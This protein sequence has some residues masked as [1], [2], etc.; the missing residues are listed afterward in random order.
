VNLGKATCVWSVRWWNDSQTCALC[1]WIVCERFTN[2]CPV[3]VN[4]HVPAKFTN[5]GHMLVKRFTNTGHI[6][7]FHRHEPCLT[8]SIDMSCKSLLQKRFT[9]TG[10]MLVK[11]FT[12]MCPVF[13]NRLWTIH[14]H[15]PCV[16]ESTCAC[17]IHKHRAHVAETI[18]KHFFWWVLQHCTGFARLQKRF[19][20]T[21][22]M[23]VKR[24]TN[25]GHICTRSHN[26]AT[27][28]TKLF[29]KRPADFPPVLFEKHLLFKKKNLLFLVAVLW[30]LVKMC[31]VCVNLSV[32]K[33]FSGT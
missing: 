7:T 8:C 33:I 9:N 10:H 2:M 11:R 15:V 25:T 14:K 27:K 5:T 23:L 6:C 17:K 32:P 29:S 22:H 1:S 26:T 12:N 21:G 13:V 18:H 20:N 4:Q 28:N 19:T 3:F 24:F 31:P 16:C 30:L